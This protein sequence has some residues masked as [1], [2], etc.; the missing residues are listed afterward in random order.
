MIH[1]PSG[2]EY[3]DADPPTVDTATG[4]TTDTNA[5]SSASIGSAGSGSASIPAA[6]AALPRPSG[7]DRLRYVAGSR[8]AAG[9]W[10]G[11]I[12]DESTCVV[13]K[14]ELGDNN[15]YGSID[16]IIPNPNPTIHVTSTLD[17]TTNVTT[18]VTTITYD[19]VSICSLEYLR[20]LDLTSTVP[21]GASSSPSDRRSLQASGPSGGGS[22]GKGSGGKGSGGGGSGGGG[23]RRGPPKPPRGSHANSPTD[24]GYIY[25]E[26]PGM[27]N[28]TCLPKLNSLMLEGNHIGG[29]I[30]DWLICR[31]VEHDSQ[32]GLHSWDA[33][34]QPMHLRLA[35]NNLANPTRRANRDPDARGYVYGQLHDECDP[36]NSIWQSR[37]DRKLNNRLFE[38]CGRSEGLSCSGIAG[39]ADESCSAFGYQDTETAEQYAEN[40]GKFVLTFDESTCIECPNQ[41]RF[42]ILLWALFATLLVMLV[43]VGWG[44]WYI[45]KHQQFGKRYVTTFI[46]FISH[47]QTLTIIGSMRLE[48]PEIIKEAMDAIALDFMISLVRA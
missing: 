38:T 22:D 46:I 15:L 48:W 4:A 14:L 1:A 41:N 20:H 42:T 39:G 18:N 27:D 21:Q 24:R 40:I 33:N 29:K 11:T 45:V 3:C 6:I 13:V 47:V 43:L 36:T 34:R 19:P 44:A 10:T 30:P 8:C 16:F 9:T 31:A 28:V 32:N 23:P 12:A 26:L 5:S 7:G 35:N 2:H 25:G 37:Y 17:P